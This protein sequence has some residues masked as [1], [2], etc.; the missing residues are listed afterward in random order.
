MDRQRITIKQTTQ[1][2]KN[3]ISKP[4]WYRN[5]LHSSKHD[6][7]HIGTNSHRIRYLMHDRALHQRTPSRHTSSNPIFNTKVNTRKSE[8]PNS[9][10]QHSNRFTV[11]TWRHSN[12]SHRQFGRKT[13]TN[14]QRRRPHGPLD[15]HNF[16]T[17]ISTSDHDNFSIPS[18]HSPDQRD[19][20]HCMAPTKDQ[21]QLTR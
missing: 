11:S 7:D 1:H 5:N 10:E 15:L 8:P 3:N 21:T 16:E 17:K 14:K 9:L 20:N 13:R 4:E 6:N 2:F 18:Q 19:R 12:I